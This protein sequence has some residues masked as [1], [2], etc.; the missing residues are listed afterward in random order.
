MD[1]MVVQSPADASVAM[2]YV[3]TDPGSKVRA[4]FVRKL[5]AGQ[6]LYIYGNFVTQH[7]Y[8][9]RE[10][11]PTPLRPTH[12]FFQPETSFGDQEKAAR[13][14]TIAAYMAQSGGDAVRASALFVAQ[15]TAVGTARGA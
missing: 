6:P 8:V 3:A 4:V 13:S 9:F 12:E 2:V 15:N 5:D 7:P 1:A 11:V 10:V 14:A